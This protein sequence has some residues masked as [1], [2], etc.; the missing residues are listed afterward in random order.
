MSKIVELTEEAVSSLCHQLTKYCELPVIDQILRIEEWGRSDRVPVDGFKVW[1]ITEEGH[2][3]YETVTMA[4]YKTCVE[5]V[6]V[7]A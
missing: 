2:T 3:N 7:I 6:R 4:V 1:F 5:D